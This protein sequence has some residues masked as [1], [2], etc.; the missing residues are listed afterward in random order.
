MSPVE[1]RNF[2][3]HPYD[4]PLSLRC[5]KQPARNFD[6]SH[7]RV[8]GG[9]QISVKQE[10]NPGSLVEARTRIQGK[11]LAFIGRVIWSRQKHGKTHCLGLVFD[12]AEDAFRARMIEQLCHIEHYQRSQRAHGRCLDVHD[13]ANEWIERFSPDFPYIEASSPIT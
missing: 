5:I 8:A 6:V 11:R 2:I 7:Y 13:A 3:K 4:H 9:I 12:N 1:D 10:F